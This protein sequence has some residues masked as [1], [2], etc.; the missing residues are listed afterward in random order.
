VDEIRCEGCGTCA[1]TCC[2]KAITVYG[3]LK[4]QVEAQI[5]AI[6]QEET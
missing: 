2:N 3:F 4:D 6:V 5:R 1:V